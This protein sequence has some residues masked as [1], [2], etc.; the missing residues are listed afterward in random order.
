MRRKLVSHRR[1]GTTYRSHLQGSRCPRKHLCN[2]PEDNR[3]QNSTSY[4]AAFLKNIPIVHQE[5]H[6]LSCRVNTATCF[7]LVYKPLSGYTV[8]KNM[9]MYK[10]N[11][12]FCELANLHEQS[13]L[14]S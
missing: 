10:A 14:I 13:F 5:Q 9:R 8:Y 4:A 11:I 7:G 2:S 3:I 12:T 1:F 6:C